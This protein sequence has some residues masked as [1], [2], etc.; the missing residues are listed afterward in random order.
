MAM[1]VPVENAKRI[2][3]CNWIQRTSFHLALTSERLSTS[4]SSFRSSLFLVDDRHQSPWD[5]TTSRRLVSSLNHLQPIYESTA[6][7][8]VSVK[9]SSLGASSRLPSA[10]AKL[11]R[12]TKEWL[13]IKKG[14]WTFND[15][16]TGR[17]LIRQWSGIETSHLE[18]SFQQ[19]MIVRRWLQEHAVVPIGTENSMSLSEIREML[20]QCLDSWR[21]VDVERGRAVDATYQ[22]LRLLQLF[23]RATKGHA[24]DANSIATA[25]TY[26]MFINVLAQYPESDTSCRD[27]MSIYHQCVDRDLQF[28]NDL[29]RALSKCSAHHSEAAD[30]AEKVFQHLLNLAE[31]KRNSLSP[32]SDTFAALLH[33]WANAS[34]TRA[35]AAQRTEAM[36]NEMMRS[37]FHL[38]NTTCFNIVI[39]AWARQG[40]WKKAEE[41]LWR[42]LK[43]HQDHDTRHIYPNVVSFNSAIHA[44]ANQKNGDREAAAAIAE[45][46]LKQ[47]VDLGCNPTMETFTNVMQTLMRTT[48]PGPKV[49]SILDSLEE[50]YA[51]GYLTVAPEKLCYLM[52]I[53]AWG[54][55]AKTCL[56][57]A[58]TVAPAETAER[59]LRRMQELAKDPSR[60]DLDPCCIIYSA[61]IG[62][63]AKCENEDAPDRALLLFREMQRR[64]NLSRAKH[65]APNNVT[66]NSLVRAFCRHGRV[67]EVRQLLQ[68]ISWVD[69]NGDLTPFHI[70]LRSYGTRARVDGGKNALGVLRDVENR[71]DL[72]PTAIT[73]SLVLVAL[74]NSSASGA[75]QQAEDLFWRLVDN[76]G[77]Q[78]TPDVRL[79]NCV[80]RAWANCSQGGA[81]ERAELF[82][83]RATIQSNE[84]RIAPDE[85]S[86][87]HMIHAWSLSGRGIS[88]QKVLL[89][90]E[91]IQSLSIDGSNSDILRKAQAI[92]AKIRE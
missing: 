72:I 34:N 69:M 88:K 17:F 28:F 26:S 82:L 55:T 48:N 6:L 51:K 79:M 15:I 84:P 36:L 21:N 60:S 91:K 2:L 87:L 86:H 31:R 66:V 62:C 57:E 76:D 65:V 4:Q 5:R 25:K 18:R 89:H 70:I 71:V 7:K 45:R 11:H 39:D 83:E 9:I 22:V 42:M 56:P 46:L 10:V 43:L 8:R 35:D 53:Q 29:L 63:W 78:V 47:M 68:S 23:E 12:K 19:T 3:L 37:N 1:I 80:L 20:H 54:R 77:C 85:I 44:C 52:A 58:S 30:M 61:L 27:I 41:I 38:V 90:L 40:S 75:A 73:Y 74:G 92:M 16:S 59:L 50:R 81:A 67:Q 32:N 64:S 13:K 33:V 49:Q 14:S 24:Q